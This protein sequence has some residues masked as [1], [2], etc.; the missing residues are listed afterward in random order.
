VR[1]TGPSAPGWKL[2]DETS[3]VARCKVHAVNVDLRGEPQFVTLNGLNKFDPKI[4]RMV[5]I[6]I[7]KILSYSYI[8]VKHTTILS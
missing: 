3:L 5:L 7:I 6:K 1:H 8:T 2:D 4:T